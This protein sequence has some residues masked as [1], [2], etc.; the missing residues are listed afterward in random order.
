MVPVTPLVKYE[1]DL[2]HRIY[3]RLSPIWNLINIIKDFAPYGAIDYICPFKTRMTKYSYQ[4]HVKYIDKQSVTRALQDRRLV[5]KYDA[6]LD[7]N[8]RVIPKHLWDMNFLARHEECGQL[9]TLRE[10]A[11]HQAACDYQRQVLQQE[12]Q[13]ANQIVAQDNQDD[14]D[15]VV[16]SGVEDHEND[17][18]TD[19]SVA[20]SN[21][22][23]NGSI[24][25]DNTNEETEE[26]YKNED[27]DEAAAAVQ[28]LPVFP[29]TLESRQFMDLVQKVAG[30]M[31]NSY[32]DHIQ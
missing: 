25:K 17:H 32:F 31:M 11:N 7:P 21:K 13:N 26:E 18:D 22:E 1:N 15:E 3:I 4:A 30:V 27:N 19:G 24:K 9:I 14:G 23:V 16:P 6:I 8:C 2:G 12:A 29:Q 10:A 28:Q 20:M 5:I